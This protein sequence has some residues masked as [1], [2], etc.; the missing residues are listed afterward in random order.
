M[1]QEI[2]I[3][4]QP[5]LWFEG[6]ILQPYVSRYGTHLRRGRYA[7][8]TQR[9][10]VT[11]A[12]EFVEALEMHEACCLL[13]YTR[14]TAQQVAYQLGYNDPAYISRTYRRNLRL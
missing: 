1:S 13:V 8:S 3:Q 14:L 2:I 5:R 7:P 11:S 10:Y 9:V 4:S 6:S 12:Q